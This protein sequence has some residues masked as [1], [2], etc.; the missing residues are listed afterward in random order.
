MP[1][2]PPA[3]PVIYLLRASDGDLLRD[4]WTSFLV[5][6][7]LSQHFFFL[8]LFSWI[9]RYIYTLVCPS[10][11]LPVYPSFFLGR[12]NVLR[13]LSSLRQSSSHVVSLPFHPTQQLTNRV[14]RRYTHAPSTHPAE[15]G[16][17]AKQ[18]H[19]PGVLRLS[20]T[21]AIEWNGE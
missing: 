16:G 8:F 17:V 9:D 4:L 19:P 1:P 13:F 21:L 14:R 3:R 20:K 10:A 12:G 15:R 18:P 2:L 7:S 5:S 11:R 6:S